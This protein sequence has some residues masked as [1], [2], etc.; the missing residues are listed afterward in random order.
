VRTADRR[1]WRS[2]SGR[3]AGAVRCG[4]PPRGW[5]APAVRALRRSGCPGRAGAASRRA[6][7]R[8]PSDAHRGRWSDQRRSALR[9]PDR[10]RGDG[11]GRRTGSTSPRTAATRPAAEWWPTSPATGSCQCSSCKRQA[12]SRVWNPERRSGPRRAGPAPLSIDER[13]RTPDASAWRS[14][15]PAPKPCGFTA[16][17]PRTPA[18][19]HPLLESTATCAIDQLHVP[20]AD[21]HRYWPQLLLPSPTR[22][23]RLRDRQGCSEC[24]HERRATSPRS[25]ATPRSR[26]SEAATRAAESWAASTRPVRVGPTSTSASVTGLAANSSSIQRAS[27][28]SARWIP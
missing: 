24:R 27:R 13:S 4:R 14:S 8:R 17:R 10:R 21:Q 2:V 5:L 26:S 19:A 7:P 18:D 6:G 12:P 11:P 23:R 9:P 22:Y 20:G 15:S 25:Y 28:D 16:C 3:R 1:T